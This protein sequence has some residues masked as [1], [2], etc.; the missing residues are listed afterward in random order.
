MELQIQNKERNIFCVRKKPTIN[1]IE[2]HIE[3][4]IWYDM[5]VPRVYILKCRKGGEKKWVPI[6]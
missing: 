2:S 1:D 3:K 6:K 4:A 5:S